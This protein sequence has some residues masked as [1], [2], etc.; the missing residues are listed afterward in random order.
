MVF[1]SRIFA[2]PS[3]Q[4]I[5]YQDRFRQIELAVGFRKLTC[6]RCDFASFYRFRVMHVRRSPELLSSEEEEVREDHLRI[7]KNIPRFAEIPE[8]VRCR[9]CDEVLGVYTSCIF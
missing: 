2:P 8:T 4:T 7:W 3:G 9:R 1:D 5:V 6:H